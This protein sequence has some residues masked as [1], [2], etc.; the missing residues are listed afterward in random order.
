MKIEWDPAKARANVA[1][2][3]VHFSD[4]EAAFYDPFAIV[5]PDHDAEGEERFVLLGADA[6]G[7]IVTAAYTYRGDAVR[8]ISAR[9]ATRRERKCYEA[10]IRF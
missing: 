3:G 4:V 7:K 10:G 9:P 6:T 8:L 2:H 1:K 5:V